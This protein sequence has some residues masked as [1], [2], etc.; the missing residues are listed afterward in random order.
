MDAT[1]FFHIRFQVYTESLCNSVDI[2]KITHHL[3]RITNGS[4]RKA[5][6]SQSF[7]VIFRHFPGRHCEFLRP[8]AEGLIFIGQIRFSPIM[9]NMLCQFFILDLIPE[10]VPMGFRSVMAMIDPR[11]NCSNH[12]SLRA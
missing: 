11:N 2:I 7:Y 10:V 5:G 3:C 4:L 12:F 6:C 9:F 8:S 1:S